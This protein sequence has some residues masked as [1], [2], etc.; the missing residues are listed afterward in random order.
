MIISSVLHSFMLILLKGKTA[1]AYMK[2]INRLLFIIFLLYSGCVFSQYPT[3]TN[4]G[5][6]INCS[7]P[8]EQLFFD[9]TQTTNNVITQAGINI[10][11]TDNQCCSE[12]NNAGCLFFNVIVDPT[13]TGVNFS[14][15]GAGG[16]V[17]I[18]YDNC[19]QVF[20]GNT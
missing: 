8:I 6:Y 5:N 16:N 11:N 19:N 7:G 4:Y 2:I 13:A 3:T 17:D 14:Q 20:P 15:T 12:S 10:Q 18:Y 9:F 1:A